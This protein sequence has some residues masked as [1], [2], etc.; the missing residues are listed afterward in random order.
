MEDAPNISYRILSYILSFFS[1][2]Q[3]ERVRV[4]EHRFIAGPNN[5]HPD[6]LPQCGRGGKCPV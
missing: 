4:R 1:F 3:R 6:P 5:P 2:S